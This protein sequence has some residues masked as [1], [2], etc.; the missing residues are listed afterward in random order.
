MPI[1]LNKKKNPFFMSSHKFFLKYDLQYNNYVRNSVIEP[2][3]GK[4]F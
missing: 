4:E 1:K 2:I 3:D